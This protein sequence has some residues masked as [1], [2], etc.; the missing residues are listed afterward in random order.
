MWLEAPPE[1]TPAVPQVL[2]LS[3]TP[4]SSLCSQE[5]RSWSL[6]P[7]P[8]CACPGST[9][10]YSQAHAGPSSCCI[11]FQDEKSGDPRGDCQSLHSRGYKLIKRFPA[12]SRGPESP[13]QAL[14]GGGD[15]GGGN[16][17]AAGPLKAHPVFLTPGEE[18]GI[19]EGGDCRGKGL[20]MGSS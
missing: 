6:H 13:S 10:V 19:A 11:L 3:P 17:R 18:K 9:G 4:R 14:G 20:T 8:R 12:L 2:P 16:K 15:G 7:S 1:R 5:G